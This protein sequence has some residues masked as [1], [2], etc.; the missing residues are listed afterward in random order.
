MDC[1][2]TMRDQMRSV[3]LGYDWEREVTTCEPDYYRWNQWLFKRFYEE[4][5][6]ERK[7]GEVNWC[8]SCE[9]VLANEQVE[10]E[11]EHCWRCGTPVESARSSTSGS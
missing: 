10:G 7:G 8:P 11:D 4:G 5:L 6:A 2:D 9:T 3:G 1:I